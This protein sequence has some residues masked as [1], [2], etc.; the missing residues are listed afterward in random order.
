MMAYDN[1]RFVH[2]K[3]LE[4]RPDRNILMTEGDGQGYFL[5]Q[6]QLD[7]DGATRQVDYRHAGFANI[8]FVDG[9]IKIYSKYEAR[10]LS[11]LRLK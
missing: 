1:T 9:H 10:T 11:P 6:D 8:L 7:A 4:H 5:T 2:V 3:Q